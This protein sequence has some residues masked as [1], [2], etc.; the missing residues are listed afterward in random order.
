[1]ATTKTERITVRVNKHYLAIIDSLVEVG[2]LENRSLAIRQALKEY[3]ER[4]TPQ[5]Q[6]L[7]QK[8]KEQDQ[9]MALAAQ[10]K[11]LR[12]LSEQ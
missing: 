4:H 3:V 8:K 1:M 6:M 5:V 11:D 9:L 12:E 7:V 10:V 2:E